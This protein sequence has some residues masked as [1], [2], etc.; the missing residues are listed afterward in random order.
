MSLG[1]LVWD[2]RELPQPQRTLAGQAYNCAKHAQRLG[3]DARLVS[4][5]GDDELG[6]QALAE[7]ARAGFAA[8]GITAVPVSPTASVRVEQGSAG[9][10]YVPLTRLDWAR[11]EFELQLA[12]ALAGA[13]ALLFGA[14]LQGTLLPQPRLERAL[15]GSA[16]PRFVACDLNLRRAIAAEPLRE[17]VR[18]CS[19]IKL[20]DVELGRVAESAGAEPIRFLLESPGLAFVV[21]TRGKVGAVLHTREQS[22][23]V[24]A[25]P[26]ERVDS[27]GA[28][29]A[30]FAALS[31]SLLRGDPP[32]AALVRAVAY[33]TSALEHGASR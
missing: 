22:V 12:G 19:F 33:A 32:H 26:L 28:G 6:Q 23:D 1:E 25:R 13:E 31:C 5:I 4:A 20:N 3:A 2:E 7:L 10:Q 27:V 21:E 11:F 14:F 15:S 16:R 17:L 18:L 30:L 29:D 24:P 8:D 9:P